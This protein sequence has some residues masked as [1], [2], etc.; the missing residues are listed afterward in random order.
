[1]SCLA[2]AKVHDHCVVAATHRLSAHSMQGL[3][4]QVIPRMALTAYWVC[5][6]TVMLLMPLQE[7]VVGLD[8][9]VCQWWCAFV[10]GLDTM[11]DLKRPGKQADLGK[12]VIAAGTLSQDALHEHALHTPVCVS[13][14]Q[15]DSLKWG[16]AL[17]AKLRLYSSQ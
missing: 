3:G 16:C 9:T 8:V 1:M 17:L 2:A 14:Q 13:S 15:T 12:L 7:D 6:L 5:C 11:T 4:F 10:Q